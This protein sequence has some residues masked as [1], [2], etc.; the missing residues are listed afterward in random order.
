MKIYKDPFFW[1]CIIAIMQM[2]VGVFVSYICFTAGCLTLICSLL[3]KCLSLL[4]D[5]KQRYVYLGMEMHLLRLLWADDRKRSE[6][7][8]SN[9]IRQRVQKYRNFKL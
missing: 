9:M 6:V 5:I 4:L 1:M 3:W 2:I 8:M 7:K